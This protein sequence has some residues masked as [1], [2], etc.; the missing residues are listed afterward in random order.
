[1]SIAGATSRLPGDFGCI[2]RTNS[3]APVPHFENTLSAVV[4]GTSTRCTRSRGRMY[5]CPAIGVG[6]EGTSTV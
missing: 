3:P 4:S 5:S 1:M 2:A 6:T